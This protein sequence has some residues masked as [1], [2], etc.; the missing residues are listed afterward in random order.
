VHHS[1]E[2]RDARG[3]FVHTVRRN[4]HSPGGGTNAS[5][6]VRSAEVRGKWLARREEWLRLGV[7]VD[8]TNVADEIIADLDQL[9]RDAQLGSVT[10]KEAH[11]IGGYS[12]D[13]LQRLVASGE[14]ENVGRK[15]R[16]RI[17][18]RDVPVKTGHRLPSVPK[19]AQF[20]ERRRI[21]AS[22]VTGENP[23]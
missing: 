6:S 18:R 14:L 2:Q 4:P 23:T 15:H 12:I 10:L 5:V 7:R 16:P 22:F 21:A 8:G 11:L 20:S 3:P 9:E 17:R 13:H 19:A 1:D